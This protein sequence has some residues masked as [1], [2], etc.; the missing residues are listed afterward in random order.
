MQAVD[1]AVEHQRLSPGPCSLHDGEPARTT[2]LLDHVDLAKPVGA[3]PFRPEIIESA[4]VH[5][6]HVLDVMQPI[7]REPDGPA[8]Q[9]CMDATATVVTD[10]H[11]VP[12]LQRIDGVLDL[13][14][15][16]I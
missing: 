7:V 6:A 2:H 3:F 1:E 9:N 12:Y 14:L 10:D 8:L 15:I 13:S 4:R 16:H 11:D 5:V